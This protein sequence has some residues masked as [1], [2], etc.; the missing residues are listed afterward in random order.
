MR[1]P[2]MDQMV[3][4]TR[5]NPSPELPWPRYVLA[6]SFAKSTNRLH[7]GNEPVSGGETTRVSELSHLG[8]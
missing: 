5:D 8:R 4:G 7:Q 1:S 3:S 6:Y 2:G